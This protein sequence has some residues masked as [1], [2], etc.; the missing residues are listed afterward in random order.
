ML[1]LT[2]ASGKDHIESVGK[3]RQNL[4]GD[5]TNLQSQKTTSDQKKEKKVE[6]P[7]SNYLTS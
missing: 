7:N 5:W 1:Y 4:E 2:Y 3:W 6:K